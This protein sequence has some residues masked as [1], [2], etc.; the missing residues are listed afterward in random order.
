MSNNTERKDGYY[1][2]KDGNAWVI[3]EWESDNERWALSATSGGF[4]DDDFSEID[5]TQII[6]NAV[7]I[8]A[9]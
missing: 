9:I 1:W 8:P 4:I 5:E 3:A 2:V 6:R 7:N